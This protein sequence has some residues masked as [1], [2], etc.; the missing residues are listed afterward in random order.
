MDEKRIAEL[1]LLF[2]CLCENNVTSRISD[3]R[4]AMMSLAYV[5]E[6]RKIKAGAA[7]LRQAAETQEKQNHNHRLLIQK[8]RKYTDLAELMHYAPHEMIKA[9][10]DGAPD[11]SSGIRRE[12]A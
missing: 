10:Y 1:N 2:I 11:Q 5:D 3:D 6:Q 12:M 9:V 7:I 4:F 8:V